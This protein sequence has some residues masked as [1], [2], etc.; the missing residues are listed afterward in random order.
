MQQRKHLRVCY[1]N[2][3]EREYSKNEQRL[4]SEFRSFFLNEKFNCLHE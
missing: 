3:I 2:S 1:R 4:Q